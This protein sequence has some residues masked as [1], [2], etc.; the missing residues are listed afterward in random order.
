[1]KKKRISSDI[2][3]EFYE[4][5][6]AESGLRKVSISK[7]IADA[8]GLELKQTDLR[9]ETQKLTNQNGALREQK[10]GLRKQLNCQKEEL[11]QVASKLGVP[12]TA[13]HCRQRIDEIET[14]CQVSDDKVDVLTEECEQASRERDDFKAKY[15]TSQEELLQAHEDLDAMQKRGFWG[16]LVNKDRTV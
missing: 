16:R 7:L 9:V 12:D 5:V 8:L 13:V 1:M 6:K 14:Q 11:K 10:T 2:D 15:E 4:Q 3:L